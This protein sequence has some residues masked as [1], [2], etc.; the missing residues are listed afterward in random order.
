LRATTGARTLT[1]TVRPLTRIG[2]ALAAACLVALPTVASAAPERS[3]GPLAPAA[4]SV[5]YQDSTGENPDAPDIT[6][7]VVSNNDAGLVTFRINVPNRP[8]FTRDLLIAIEVD[9]DNNPQTG[10]E[11]GADY[12]IEL[13]LGEAFLYRWDGSAFTRRPGDPP[14]TS[15]RFSYQR[16]ASITI[17]R[18]ELGNTSRFRFS[19]VVISG[20]TFDE[21]TGE[22]DLSTAVADF[23]PAPG[24][25]LYA[26]QVIIAKPT[27]IVKRVVTVPVL[28]K[29]GSTLALRMTVTRSDTGATIKSGRV[30]CQGRVGGAALAATTARVQGG[31]VVCVWQIPATARGKTFTG[32]ATVVFE[33]L[34]ATGSVSKKIG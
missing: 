16:G 15:L 5:T 1:R 34:R 19:V 18:A 27:L 30:T 28:P 20:A 8:Q 6:T 24:A 23:A 3:A 7:I 10:N 12:A 11:D 22:I 14:F 29:A 17:S 2:L 33:G 31:V 32:R 26:Y 13:V 4:N 25:G 21:E 9:T